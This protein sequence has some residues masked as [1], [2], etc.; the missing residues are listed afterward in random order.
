MEPTIN[1]PGSQPRLEEEAS[2]PGG[3][4]TADHVSKAK[5]RELPPKKRVSLGSV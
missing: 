1:E 3:R 5:N 2:S 4:V